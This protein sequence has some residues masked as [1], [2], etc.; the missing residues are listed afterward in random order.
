MNKFKIQLTR[1]DIG[2]L[3]AFV[4]VGALGGG[5]W[6]YLSGQLQ[7]AQA[8]DAQV[9]GD[10]NSVSVKDGIIVS[11]PNA[12]ALQANSK[13]LKDQI[14]PII[15]TKLLAKDDTLSDI[16]NEDPLAW[17]HELD[18]DVKT[19]NS[20][21]KAAGVALPASG[22]YF[23]FTRYLTES[24]GDSATAVLTKQRLAIKTIS[25]ILIKSP[26]KAITRILRS[27]EED[28]HTGPGT[29][30]HGGGDHD[31]DQLGGYAVDVPDTYT[32]YPFE[33]DFDAT[34]ESL[35]PILDNLL[36]SPYIFVVRSVEVHNDK[37]ESPKIAELA[38]MAGNNGQQN[39]VVGS[40]PGE[41]AANT[42]TLG[43]QYLFGYSILHIKLRV[44]L[45]EWNPKLTS[46]DALAPPKK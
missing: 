17:K 26:V 1:F 43:P 9:A 23:G 32:A 18:D 14:D 13:L 2:M 15:T 40:A 19:L 30:G 21:A 3:I 7:T 45:I 5:A 29:I 4:V 31:G 38:Q 12:V 8:G 36:K 27:Y 37:L 20:E 42:P 24:P 16:R 33:I 28:P 22:F 41:V 25:E 46:V 44:D 34:P 35:R 10:Y 11:Q 39:S 6:W